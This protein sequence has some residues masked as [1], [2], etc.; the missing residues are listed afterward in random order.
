M[1]LGG[2][3]LS[4]PWAVSLQPSPHSALLAG[5]GLPSAVLGPPGLPHLSMG[6]NDTVQDPRPVSCHVSACFS[7]VTGWE[8]GDQGS[9]HIPLRKVRAAESVNLSSCSVPHPPGLS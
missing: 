5:L 8:K 9:R 1:S 2:G 6:L 7:N 4:G 3:F